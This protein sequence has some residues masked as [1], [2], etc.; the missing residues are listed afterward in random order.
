[1]DFC[2]NR[3]CTIIVSGSDPFGYSQ[4]VPDVPKICNH[5]WQL[6]EIRS[7]SGFFVIIKGKVTD[8]GEKGDHH[9][10]TLS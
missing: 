10:T 8:G 2:R 5:P 7:E 1:M 3:L 9:E 6:R 4:F